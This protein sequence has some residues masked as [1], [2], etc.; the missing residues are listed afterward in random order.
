M[1]RLAITLTSLFLLALGAACSTTGARIRAN[2]GLFES[3]DAETQ[4][5]IKRGEVRLGYTAEMVRMAL[6]KPSQV[7]GGMRGT[8]EDETW[9]YRHDHRDPNDYVLAGHRRRVVFD[10]VR[11]GNVIITEPVDERTHRHLIAH[12]VHIGFRDGRVIAIQRVD[13]L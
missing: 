9:I 6:G 2:P 10:P 3:L 7:T 4:R 5:A 12:A 1:P 8:D 13:N 11:R